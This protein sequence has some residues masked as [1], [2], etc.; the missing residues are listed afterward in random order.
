M[1]EKINKSEKEDIFDELRRSIDELRRSMKSSPFLAKV[2]EKFN[3]FSILIGV[4]SFFVYSLMFGSIGLV[5]GIIAKKDKQKGAIFGIILGALSIS[6]VLI[7]FIVE[8]I[9]V[10]NYKFLI[11]AI[12][13][14]IIFAVMK[15]AGFF[16]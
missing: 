8:D 10:G 3:I 12:I 9:S 15:L 13:F 4:I 11:K 2:L 1:K 14:T 5:L 7:Y 6:L 16:D